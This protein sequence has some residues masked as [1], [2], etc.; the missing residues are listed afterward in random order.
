MN[1]FEKGDR[2]RNNQGDNCIS[3]GLTGIVLENNSCPYIEWDEEIGCGDDA[4][5][6][7]KDGHCTPQYEEHLELI[8]EES[9][10]EPKKKPKLMVH[11]AL[12]VLELPNMTEV[13]KQEASDILIKAL[14]GENNE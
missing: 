5:G 2:V 13:L 1:K 14:Q 11:L 8:E 10:T 12:Q 6:L 3:Y 4:E 9:I 7:G